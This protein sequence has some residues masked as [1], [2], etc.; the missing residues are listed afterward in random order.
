MVGGT[1]EDFGRAAPILQFMGKNIV[2]C[3]D[4]GN[5]QAVK[6]CNNMLLA[7]QMIGVAEAMNLG[8]K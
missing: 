6:I 7:I 1:Q 2:Y 4:V 8:V 3:G 5:G